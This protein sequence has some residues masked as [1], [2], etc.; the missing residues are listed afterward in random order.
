MNLLALTFKNIIGR[1]WRS[2][3]MGFYVFII[4]LVMVLA[5]SLNQAVLNKTDDIIVHGFVSHIQIRSKASIEQDM[6]SMYTG[7]WDS[8]SPIP[9]DLFHRVIS[10]INTQIPQASLDFRVRQ[11]VRLVGKNKSEESLLIGIDT[12]QSGGASNIRESFLLSEGFFPRWSGL[13]PESGE[14]MPEVMVTDEQAK[15]LM[16]T[17]GDIVQITAKT[18]QGRNTHIKARVSG[19]GV[20]IILSLF[21][22]K[23]FV[24]DIRDARHLLQFDPGQCTDILIGLPN[25]QDA[26]TVSEQLLNSAKSSGMDG[27]LTRD[28]KSAVEDLE[29][30][31]LSELKNPGDNGIK[32]STWLE[33]G[34]LFRNAGK[35]VTTSL[36]MLLAMLF[37]VAGLLIANIAASNSLERYR[38]IG[39]LLTLGFPRRTV[40]FLMLAEILGIFT[41]FACAGFV[42]AALLIVKAG[43]NI[44]SPVPAM[45]FITG[46]SLNLTVDPFILAMDFLVIIF[47]GSIAT[48]IPVMRAVRMHPQQVLD[49]RA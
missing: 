37:L 38:E 15:K 12:E 36:A 13:S 28:E 4:A 2:F 41:V 17:P 40:A 11:N 10:I 26:E 35:V 14:Q 8:L 24:M 47:Y 34:E 5:G 3:T 27:L 45:E 21:S 29:L 16:V 39:T 43:Q 25:K 48:V 6:V 19:T 7:G 44:T 31:S 1:W 20:F 42:T 30:E 49:N 46:K 9:T 22:Y 33:M 18:A 32:I 23:A